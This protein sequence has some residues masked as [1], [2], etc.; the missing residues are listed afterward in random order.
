MRA[1]HYRGRVDGDIRE[2]LI[3]RHSDGAVAPSFVGYE[4][5][6]QL[7]EM[8]V[9]RPLATN[10]RLYLPGRDDEQ[11]WVVDEDQVEGAQLSHHSGKPGLH[12]TKDLLSTTEAQYWEVSGLD[13]KAYWPDE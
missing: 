3:R 12:N 7:W 8:G 9:V 5:F 2:Y 13:P 4:P 11:Y 6:E 10:I 1:T